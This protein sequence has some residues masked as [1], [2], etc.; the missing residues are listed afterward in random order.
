M[1]IRDSL[2]SGGAGQ[3]T[4]LVG[5]GSPDVVVNVSVGFGSVRLQSTTAPSV[6]RDGVS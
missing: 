6:I 5:T 4:Y 1:C 2:Y 3:Q